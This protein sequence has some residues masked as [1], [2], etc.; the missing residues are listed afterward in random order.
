MYIIIFSNIY[1]QWDKTQTSK[2][3]HCLSVDN[4]TFMNVDY[5]LVTKN[6][7]AGFN[8]VDE[9]IEILIKI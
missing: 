5:S 2:K 9:M 6:S 1:N 7:T 3:N 8:A 4:V